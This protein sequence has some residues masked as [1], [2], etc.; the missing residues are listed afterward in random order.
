[1]SHFSQTRIVLRQ[2]LWPML[3]GAIA[4]LVSGQGCSP[5]GPD[6][7]EFP[8]KCFGEPVVAVAGP[9]VTTPLGAGQ[10]SSA[11]TLDGSRSFSKDGLGLSYQWTESGQEIATGPNP[12]VT[13]ASGAHRI[14]LR[15]TDENGNTA[16]DMTTI[17]V[18]SSGLTLNTTPSPKPGCGVMGVPTLAAALSMLCLM[19]RRLPAPR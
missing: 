16:S 6:C 12:Q 13:L 4:A 7:G 3:M 5:T 19:K 15:V 9:D 8:E 10:T 2:I 18:G 14:V 11:V 17:T 1:M